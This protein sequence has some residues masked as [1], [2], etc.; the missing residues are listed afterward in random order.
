MILFLLF[1]SESKMTVR[2][3]VQN[4]IGL[5]KDSYGK[6]LYF[7]AGTY[8]LSEPIVLPFDYTKNVNIVFDKNALIKSD[9]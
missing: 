9:F 6:T 2:L 7:P 3:L 5:V 4:L 1:G 8:N